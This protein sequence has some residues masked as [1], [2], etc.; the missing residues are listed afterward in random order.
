[1]IG[2][3]GTW[4]RRTQAVEQLGRADLD[5]ERLMREVDLIAGHFRPQLVVTVHIKLMNLEPPGC[6]GL[7]NQY[8][9]TPSRS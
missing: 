5:R 1:M 9:G 6:T 7:S 2:S 3:G 8:D 4:L